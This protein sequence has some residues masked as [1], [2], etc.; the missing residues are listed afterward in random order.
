MES[1]LRKAKP[2]SI[3]ALVFLTLISVGFLLFGLVTVTCGFVLNYH[4]DFKASNGGEELEAI[5]KSEFD[6]TQ[7]WLGLP[8]LITGA[9]SIASGMCQNNRS[10]TLVTFTCLF[11]CITL[12]LFA[13]V[14]EGVDWVKW[15]NMDRLHNTLDGKDEYSCSSTNHTCIC[16]GGNENKIISKY[17][18]C[19]NVTS[20]SGLFGGI[21]AS[22]VI[23]I[24]LSLAGIVIILKS[25]SWKPRHY[26]V[27]YNLREV[28]PVQKG[29]H[30]NEG[31]TNG[32][33]PRLAGKGGSITEIPLY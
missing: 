29:A 12:S 4:D 2:K 17:A 25:L 27:E 3:A 1:H 28:R 18:T 6:Y 15:K 31:Y 30:K 23:G 9:L 22:A 5:V 19:S 32:V 10:L 16:V 11:L 14:L 24:F 20:L 7:Y 13:M 33:A 26:L 8:F 21:A